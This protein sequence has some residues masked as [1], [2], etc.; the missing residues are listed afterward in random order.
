MLKVFHCCALLGGLLTAVAQAATVEYTLTIARQTVDFS[1]KPVTRMTINGGIPGPILHFTEGDI[2][3]IHVQNDM[4]VPTS[5]HWHGMLV[6]NDM[7]GVPYVTFPPISPGA[8]FTYQF[9]IRQAGTYWYHSH[10]ALQEQSGVYGAIVIEPRGG[11]SRF[12][13]LEEHVLVL[14]DWTDE[15]PAEVMRTLRSG[16]DFYS[17]RKRSGQSILGA[18]RT[19]HLK[20]Y[21]ERELLRMPAMDISDVAYDRF[22]VNGQTDD[23][24]AAKPG[25]RIRLRIVDGS[26]STYFHLQFAGGPMTIVAAD[27]QDVQPVEVQ[28]LLIGVAETYD[29]LVTM[30]A[31]GRF[32][33]RATSMDRSG[34]ASLWI[35][36]GEKHFAP[37]VPAPDLYATMGGFSWKKVFALTPAG[38]MGM[39]DDAVNDGRF[40]HPGMNMGD[41]PMSKMSAQSPMSHRSHPG[42]RSMNGMAMPSGHTMEMSDAMQSSPNAVSASEQGEPMPG[43]VAAPTPLEWMAGDVSSQG[44][45]VKDGSA[46]RPWSPYGKLRSTR[47]T[48]PDPTKPVHTIRLTL[49]GDME[50]YVW[51]INNRRLSPDDVIRIKQ[52]EVVKFIMINRTMMHHPMHLHGHFFRVINGQGEYSPLKHTVD[53]AP[54][55]TTVIEF[56]A[57]EQGDWF[58]HCHLLYHLH[59]GMARVVHYEGFRP[60]AATAAVRDTLYEDPFY[61]FGRG[62]FTSNM[63]EGWG[64]VSNTRNIFRAEWKAGWHGVPDLEWEGVATYGRYFNRFTSVFAGADFLGEKSSVD[65]TRGVAGVAYT[66][67]FNFYSRVWVDTERGGRATITRVFMVT[68]RLGLE[69]DAEYDTHTRWEGLAALDYTLSK[70]TALQVRWHSDYKWGAGLGFVF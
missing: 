34:R 23:T 46:E 39:S 68:P 60:D 20:D 6:P 55:S 64:E 27:G 29:V 61:L 22:L 11:E 28:R 37:L 44:L 15:S 2:A 8:T 66:L 57:D 50:R 4:K 58:F 54:M 42:N 19:G 25:E 21:F 51:F 35:G 67:P 17:V 70:H 32:E 14:S 16:N 26:A 18:I 12:A 36:A 24:L 3:R 47:V 30:P 38:T 9:P 49:D 65:K 5:I 48:A 62:A 41:M 33:F 56:N 52:G 53:V 45:L 7:D 31:D 40:D 63:T 43:M 59:A 13:G 10:S 1:G 69:I